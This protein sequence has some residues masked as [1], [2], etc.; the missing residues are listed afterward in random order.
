ML[1]KL[2]SCS[3]AI[4]KPRSV[5]PALLAQAPGPSGAAELIEALAPAQ[6]DGNEQAAGQQDIERTFR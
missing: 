2:C 1:S 5:A 4:A 6:A 3:R